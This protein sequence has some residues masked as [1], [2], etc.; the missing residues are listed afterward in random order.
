MS[1]WNEGASLGM[2][3]WRLATPLAVQLSL[4]FWEQLGTGEY[5]TKFYLHREQSSSSPPCKYLVDGP[6]I[7]YQPWLSVS[8]ILISTSIFHSIMN[9]SG[10]WLVGKGKIDRAIKILKVIAKRNSRQVEDNVWRSFE[11]GIGYYQRKSSHIF[12]QECLS[13]FHEII[14]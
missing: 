8:P 14:E 1:Q 2:Q 5:F 11:V 4:T 12:Y 7:I 10:R 13:I 3:A 6:Y 9:E